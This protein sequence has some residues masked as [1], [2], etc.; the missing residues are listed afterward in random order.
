MRKE[1]CTIERAK[2]ECDK[3]ISLDALNNINYKL[4]NTLIIPTWG[5]VACAISHMECYKYIID[6]KLKFAIICEDDLE[7]IDVKKFK[8]SFNQGI[9][10]VNKYLNDVNSTSKNILLTFNSDKVNLHNNDNKVNNDYLEKITGPFKSL[11][12][13]IIN[14]NMAK[15]LYYN[16]KPFVYQLDIQIGFLIRRVS[17]HYSVHNNILYNF[18][19]CGIIHSKQFKSDVQYHFIT[20]KDLQCIKLSNDILYKILSF[21]PNKKNLNNNIRPNNL[22]HMIQDDWMY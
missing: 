2:K 6:N 11:Q 16:L 4:Q 7:V 9:T 20:L 5:S 14:Y 19:N 13:Y 12:F 1:A 17:N 3:Y 10:I 15:N 8:I 22:I 21:L 18:K